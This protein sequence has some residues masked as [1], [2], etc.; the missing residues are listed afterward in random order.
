MRPREKPSSCK[1]C[2][3]FDKGVGYCQ[4]QRYTDQPEMTFI[5]DGPDDMA[6]RMSDPMFWKSLAGRT[7]KQWLEESDIDIKDVQFTNIVRCYLPARRNN[8]LNEG[9][10]PPTKAEAEFCMRTHLIPTLQETGAYN[11]G[12]VIVTVGNQAARFFRGIEGS[13]ESS[14]GV[15]DRVTDPDREGR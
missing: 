6:S 2:P 8:Q 10:R 5:L 1:G 11:E 7:I 3:A 9:L 12:H 4:P 14:I 15:F 13:T